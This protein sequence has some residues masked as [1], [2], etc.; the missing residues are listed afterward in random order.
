[1]IANKTYNNVINTLKNIGDMH[2][3]ITTTT[4]GDIYDI[5][6]EKNTLFPLMHINPVSVG[7]GES[8]LNYI[9]QIFSF[10][11]LLEIY[12]IDEL[13]MEHLHSWK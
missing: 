12:R 4:T 6:L 10:L 1:M 7:T 11:I 5:D 8:Q 9:F 3:Q 13:H 2:G